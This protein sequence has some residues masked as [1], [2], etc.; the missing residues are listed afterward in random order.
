MKLNAEVGNFVIYNVNP[1]RN[2]WQKVLNLD[3]KFLNFIH[4]HTAV[5]VPLTLKRL[6]NKFACILY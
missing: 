2:K 4:I 3:L 6:N 1:F 5:N